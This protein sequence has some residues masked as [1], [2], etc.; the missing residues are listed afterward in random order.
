MPLYIYI[1]SI[2]IKFLSLQEAIQNTL[3]QEMLLLCYSFSVTFLLQLFCMQNWQCSQLGEL[4][5]YFMGNKCLKLLSKKAKSI[6]FIKIE[7]HTIF[8][9]RKK[10]H[11]FISFFLQIYLNKCRAYKLPKNITDTNNQIFTVKSHILRLLCT[12]ITKDFT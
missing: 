4:R 11:F 6:I 5:V 12:L 9:I 1:L 2:Q 8:G 7:L 10:R 3:H